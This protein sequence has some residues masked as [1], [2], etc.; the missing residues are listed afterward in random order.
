MLPLLAILAAGAL[1]TIAAGAAQILGRGRAAAAVI[2]LVLTVLLSFGPALA[3]AR[4]SIAQA[5]PSTRVAAREWMIANL[6]PGSRIAADFYTAPLHDSTLVADY[7]FALAADGTLEEY[8]RAGYD[9]V[10]VSDAIYGRYQR[11]PRRYAKEVAFYE[12]LLRT[13]KPVMRFTPREVGRGPL[14]TV[15]ALHP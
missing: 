1:A 9:Y 13:F 2:L 15:F 3:Y 11:E 6:P 8:R 12:T 4:F 10:M 5:Q 7:H 14:I